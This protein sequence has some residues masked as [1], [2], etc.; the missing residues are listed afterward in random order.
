MCIKVGSMPLIDS[1]DWLGSLQE[2]ER[3]LLF[4]FSLLWLC[5]FVPVLHDLCILVF[6]FPFPYIYNFYCL[7]KKKKKDIKSHWVIPFDLPSPSSPPSNLSTHV[8]TTFNSL[9]TP[10]HQPLHLSSSMN[11]GSFEVKLPW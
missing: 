10:N 6:I 7:S 8:S 9:P 5:L 4:C 2:R 11:L 1:V 3:Q